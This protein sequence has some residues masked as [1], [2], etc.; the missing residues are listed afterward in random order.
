[1]NVNTRSGFKWSTDFQFTKNQE[2]II[3]LYNGAIDDVGNKWFIGKPLTAQ[4]DY[5]KAGIWQTSEADLA[6]SYGFVPGQIKVQD[7]NGDGKI[8]PADRV[9]LGSE[10]PSWTGGM[11]NRFSFKGFDLSVFV[12]ARVGSIIQSGFHQNNNALAGRYEQIK[13]NYWTPNNPTNDFPRPNSSQEFPV[14]NTAIIYFDGTFVKVRNINFGYTFPQ[15]IAQKLHLQS[16]RLFSSIQQ[17]F[18]FS[19]YRSK[20]NGVDPETANGTVSNSVVPATR[21]TTFGLNVKF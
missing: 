9:Y 11:T 20:Y 21:V 5:K 10:I 15:T 16:L 18:I 2:S 3:S 6:K 17:P 1:M 12:Y 8:T 4:F 14:Y 13:V 7:T 19:S